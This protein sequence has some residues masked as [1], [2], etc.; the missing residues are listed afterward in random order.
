MFYY[1]WNLVGP[2]TIGAEFAYDIVLPA[3]GGTLNFLTVDRGEPS[4]RI[5][6]D[7]PIALSSWCCVKCKV[8][9]E[10]RIQ[11]RG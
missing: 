4:S 11:F 10:R 6:I 1:T 9:V 5:A 8:T 7:L 3:P 2:W